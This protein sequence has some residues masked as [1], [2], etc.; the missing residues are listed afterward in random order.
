MS[1]KLREFKVPER[2]VRRDFKCS[3]VSLEKNDRFK[4]DQ[5]R[6]NIRF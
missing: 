5:F 3:G 1:I 6:E 4:T 2:S